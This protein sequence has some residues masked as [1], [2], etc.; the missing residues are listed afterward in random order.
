[1]TIKKTILLP[2]MVAAIGVT[3]CGKKASYKSK[4]SSSRTSKPAIN[5]KT[6]NTP[7]P[8]AVESTAL[9]ILA[10]DSVFR[11]LHNSK[12]SQLIKADVR[13][14][15]M[16]VNTTGAVSHV[17][18]DMILKSEDNVC[19]KKQIQKDVKLFQLANF[20]SLDAK[21]RIRCVNKSC[22]QILMIIEDKKLVQSG[23]ENAANA[24]AVEQ[25]GAVAILFHKENAQTY[26]PHTTEAKEIYQVNNAEVGAV[27][28]QKE[29]EAAQ[30]II[31]DNSKAQ[32]ISPDNAGTPDNSS[33][34]Q[35]DV[36][37]PV[38][39][40]E[41]VVPATIDDEDQDDSAPAKVDS[42]QGAKKD[43]AARPAAPNAIDDEDQDDS[44]A[45]DDED[46]DDSQ[47]Q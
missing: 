4:V 12:A 42:A 1:M 17:S 29:V 3:A 21:H 41:S 2:L 30:K 22:D 35:S 27:S 45:S 31:D 11:L 37:A 18:V 36:V 10:Q 28:C 9:D 14:V 44:A 39:A 15:T 25:A 46:R 38:P 16:T 40:V 5:P 34:K 8:V 23:N 13:G 24:G 20:E 19:S 6:V 26:K 47:A 7:A 33:D 43:D 32:P